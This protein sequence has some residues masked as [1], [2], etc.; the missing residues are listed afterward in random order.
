[1]AE[2]VAANGEDFETLVKRSLETIGS[3]V[4]EIAATLN[5][6]KKTTAERIGKLESEMK[7]LRNDS[8]KEVVS[9]AIREVPCAAMQV[10]LRRTGVVSEPADEEVLPASEDEEEEEGNGR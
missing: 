6:F 8:I 3:N 1:M 9:Q 7:G 4:L 5:D 2:N 10:G